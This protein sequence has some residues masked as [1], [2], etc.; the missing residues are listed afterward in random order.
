MA[1]DGGA[2]RGSEVKAEM[3][4]ALEGLEG[5]VR[6]GRAAIARERS[7]QEEVRDRGGRAGIQTRREVVE[8]EFVRK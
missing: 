7:R 5:L 8:D 6:E 2:E 1:R 4:R 3:M